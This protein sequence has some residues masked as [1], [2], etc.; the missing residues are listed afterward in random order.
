MKLDPSINH[1]LNKVLK[2]ELTAINQLFLHARMHQNWGLSELG[3]Y[4]YGASIR[5]MK[6]ADKL[7][8]R[9]LFLEG[10]PNLQ[11]LGHLKIGEVPA[12]CITCDHKLFIEL[13]KDLVEAIEHCEGQL[14][15]ESRQQLQS[16]LEAVEEDIDWC[17]T[18]EDLIEKMGIERY[19]QSQY[20]PEED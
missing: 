13:Q 2:T 15:Y 9:I 12:E 7:I 20:S 14:D 5:A 1:M 8:K 16:L 4:T 3:E 11:D 17:E 6:Q 18:Q 10:L 19:I